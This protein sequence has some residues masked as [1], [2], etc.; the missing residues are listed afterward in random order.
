MDQSKKKSINYKKC[1]IP[2]IIES[3]K[4]LLC[5]KHAI[6]NLLQNKVANCKSLKRIASKLS[7]D[8]DI[9]MNELVDTKKGYY[10]ISV[11]LSFFNEQKIYEVIQIPQS[12]FNKISYRQSPRLI[13]YVFGDGTHWVSVRKTNIKS[14]Y[15]ELDSLKD[16]PIKIN[17]VKKWLLENEQLLALKI[18]HKK[19]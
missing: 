14:C 6:N 18:L 4:R 17:T 16:E 15:Y 8:L 5:G 9:P 3:Q 1:N 19:V 12:E 2:K 13:G 7:K 11:L 10:D